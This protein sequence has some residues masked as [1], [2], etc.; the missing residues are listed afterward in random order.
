[1]MTVSRRRVVQTLS[2]LAFAGGLGLAG[3]AGAQQF[4]M[5][6]TTTASNDLD[7]QWLMLLKRDVEAASNGKIKAN[8]YPA[9]QLGSAETTIEGVTMGTVE[10]AMNASG[11]YEGLEPRFA[12]LAVPGVIQSMAQ[13]A[14]VLADPDVRKMLGTIGRDKGVEVL[15]ALAHSPVG[16][17]SRRPISALTD[18]KGMKIRV[19]GSALLIE[20]LKQLGASPIAMSLGEVLPAFQN[21]TIDGVYAGTTIFSALKYYDISKTLTLLPSTFVVIVGLVNSD[22]MKSLGPSEALVREAAG[23]ADIEG[24][25]WGEGDVAN[26]KML[27]EK[28]GGQTLTL[29]ADDAKKY[30]DI[31]V[32]TALRNLNP[33]T[34]ADYEVLK[35]VSAKYV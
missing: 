8:V 2:G 14:K 9:S 31:V 3:R 24:A 7:N 6:L 29:P 19:P 20:Q 27:W 28:N 26:A 34:R 25:V 21:G 11:T 13:G 4:T 15:T 5:K 18:F 32:P 30:L 1:M 16:I 12:V 17:V 10:V 22:Y 33:A 35:A 23:K